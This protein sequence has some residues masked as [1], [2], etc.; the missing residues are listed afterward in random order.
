MWQGQRPRALNGGASTRKVCVIFRS[1]SLVDH[2]GGVLGAR[3]SLP[4]MYHRPFCVGEP[5]NPPP[6]PHLTQTGRT[7][8]AERHPVRTTVPTLPTR[9]T[10]QTVQHRHPAPAGPLPLSL[11][12][13]LITR[14]AHGPAPGIVP[15]HVP[16]CDGRGPR[17]T[18]VRHAATSP[19]PHATASTSTPFRI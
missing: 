11:I 1:W 7:H 18:S 3:E 4:H 15:W 2:D 19:Q 13:T 9:T 12:G 10:K 17:A 5:T 6:L 8:V 14:P 16:R